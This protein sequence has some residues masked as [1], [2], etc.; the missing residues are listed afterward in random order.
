M[1]AVIVSVSQNWFQTDWWLNLKLH[2]TRTNT[3]DLFVWNYSKKMLQPSNCVHKTSESMLETRYNL[4]WT[5]LVC[6]SQFRKIESRNSTV[7][8]CVQKMF[9]QSSSCH[10]LA[11]NNRCSLRTYPAF[12]SVLT[13]WAVWCSMWFRNWICRMI[14]SQCVNIRE[15]GVTTYITTHLLENGRLRAVWLTCFLCLSSRYVNHRCMC[16]LPLLSTRV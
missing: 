12:R 10:T 3:N 7:N 15:R 11:S 8:V 6:V 2:K 16:P 14:A 5:K 13:C 9:S 4:Y 1:L